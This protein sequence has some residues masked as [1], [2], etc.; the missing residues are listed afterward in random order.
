MISPSLVI[1][2]LSL[3]VSSYAL[4]RRG[5]R[6]HR[7]PE[8]AIGQRGEKGDVG[9]TGARGP[10]G[11]PGKVIERAQS[12]AAARIGPDSRPKLLNKQE[13]RDQIAAKANDPDFETQIEQIRERLRDASGLIEPSPDAQT[14]Q[15]DWRRRNAK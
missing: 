6:G 9:D 13:R 1:S 7:G 10:Q 15:P 8:G 5:P 4:I 3:I 11:E 2:I 12:I 14:N